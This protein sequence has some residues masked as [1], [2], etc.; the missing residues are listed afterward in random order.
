MKPVAPVTSHRRNE[1]DSARDLMR[2]IY[3]TSQHSNGHQWPFGLVSDY[4]TVYPDRMDPKTN[5]RAKVDN[6][7]VCMVISHFADG[8]KG[9]LRVSRVAWGRKCGLSWEVHEGD[10][11]AGTAE[12]PGL[13]PALDDG[14][15]TEPAPLPDPDHA[16]RAA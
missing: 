4:A 8:L 6:D 14:D 13:H 5:T 2:E 3:K 15:P 1:V 9:S 10:R 7:D 16:D 11:T 12:V